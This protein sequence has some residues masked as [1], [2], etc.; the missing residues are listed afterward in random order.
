MTCWSRVAKRGF[1][2]CALL[3]ICLA[4][5]QLISGAARPTEPA[6]QA[7][8]YGR[9]L[10]VRKALRNQYFLSRYPQIH[11]YNLYITL[12]VSNQTYCTEYE[13]P[14]LDEIDDVT[15]ATNQDL[16]VVMKGK[17][18]TIHTPKERKLKTRLMNEN[19]C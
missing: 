12:R 3:V 7:E 1:V 10:S 9:I 19:Q 16:V 8:Q 6:N 11:Y 4:P 5:V 18:I 15:S 13:T 2:L 14:V 17:T